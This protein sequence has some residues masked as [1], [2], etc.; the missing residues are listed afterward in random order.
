M[1]EVREVESLIRGIDEYNYRQLALLS[2]AIRSPA[3]RY[4]FRSH[5]LGHNASHR[6]ARTDL[7]TL[8]HRGLLTSRRVGRQFVFT[9]IPDIADRLRGET[10]ASI[11]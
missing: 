3:Q 9:P 7:L 10:G 11:N 2:N 4:T 1:R 8:V 5:S 6:T